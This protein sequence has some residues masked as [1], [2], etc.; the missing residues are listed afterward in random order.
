[1]DKTP[2]KTT[3]WLREAQAQLDWPDAQR[4]STATKAVVHASRDRL[5]TPKLLSLEFSFR[6]FSAWGYYD[7]WNVIVRKAA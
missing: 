3:I 1:L 2:Q 5:P 6:H 7:G 4:A